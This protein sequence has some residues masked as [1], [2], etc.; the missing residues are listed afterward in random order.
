[1]TVVTFPGQ[2]SQK[3]GFLSPWLEDSASRS[4]LEDLSTASGIDLIRHGTESDAETIRDT[5]VA[6]PLIV[7]A[8]ILTWDALV[9]RLGDRV[10]GAAVAGHSVGEIAAAYA[11]GIFDAA[12]A[13]RF[14]VKRSQLMA[15]DAA[16]VTTGMSAIIGGSEGDVI[17]HL[18]NLD[19]S[20][21][22]FNGAGQIVAAGEPEQLEA[23]RKN[24]P[25]GAR[26]I[27]LKV[28]GA[29]HTRWMAD[30]QAALAGLEEE[31]SVAKPTRPIHTNRD[32]SVVTDGVTYRRYLIEQVNRPVHWDLCMNAFLEAGYS[33]LVE[34]APAG[35]LV[36]LAKRGMKG[37]PAAAINVPADIDTA[38]ELF[39]GA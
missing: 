26:V 14:V 27:P 3:P 33:G 18:N 20:P 1:M 7:A 34:A 36:G 6:Q 23:L 8:G 15:Q 11:A 22:N 19:L 13:I 12:T 31:F 5:A 39:P 32:G 21:A 16:A 25:A 2:G 4:T 37:V 9:G 28:A 17:E 30:A 24:P 10:D 35:T 29:F 38:A